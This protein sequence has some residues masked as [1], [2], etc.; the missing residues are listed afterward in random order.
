MNVT[1]AGVGSSLPARSRAL[2]INVCG[3]WVNAL[4]EAVVFGE[5][6]VKAAPSSCQANTRFW[7]EVKLSVPVKDTVR[8]VAEM[9]APFAGLAITVCGG[10]LSTMTP[11]EMLAEFPARSVAE[12]ANV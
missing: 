8:R 2:T 7:T 10:V 5:N 6:A 11:R 4:S 1:L 3:P 9:I 12:T